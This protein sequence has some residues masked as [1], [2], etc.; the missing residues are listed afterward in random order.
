MVHEL[1]L[2]NLITDKQEFDNVAEKVC[3][4][5]VGTV[6]QFQMCMVCSMV[7]SYCIIIN[8]VV[9]V[10]CLMYVVSAD[11]VA[12]TTSANNFVC[13][14]NMGVNDGC[15]LQRGEGVKGEDVSACAT[16]TSMYN[17]V[18]FM[19]V[20]EGCVLQTDHYSRCVEL[21]PV[22]DVMFYLGGVYLINY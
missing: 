16:L 6:L 5:Q 1:L 13:S 11:S 22:P 12:A 21:V 14:L 8:Y 7:N 19:G 10:V 2:A 18:C 3:S 20:N 4:K 15:V 9:I 17:S